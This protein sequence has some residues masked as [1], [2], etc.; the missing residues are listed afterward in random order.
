MLKID[1]GTKIFGAL[2]LSIL[3]PCIILLWRFALS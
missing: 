1:L 2:F 3:L